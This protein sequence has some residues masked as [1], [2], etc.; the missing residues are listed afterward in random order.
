GQITLEA[1]DFE[2]IQ[3]CGTV[4]HYRANEVVFSEGEPA[5]SV[6]FIESGKVSIFL[7]EFTNRVEIGQREAGSFF[8]EMA[9]LNKGKRTASVTAI[10]DTTLILLDK[11][12]FMRLMDTDCEVN[13]KVNRILALRTEELAL[14]ENLLATTGIKGS[15]L[16]VSIKGDPSMRESAFDRERRESPMDRVLS[17]LVPTLQVLLLERCVSEIS[18]HFNSG[19]IRLTSIFDPFN[20]EIHPANKLIDT[21]Y[22]DRHFPVLAYAEKIRLIR[23]LYDTLASEFG[24]L[25]L[26]GHYK[27]SYVHR[28]HHWQPLAE[29][30]IVRVINKLVTL[31]TIP[32]FYLRNMGISI[33][34]DAIRMQFNC[35]GTH[36][37]STGE[38]DRFLADNLGVEDV[39]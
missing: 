6:Y 34:R 9:V 38:Y 10:T 28:Y 15:H 39:T 32:N 5:E 27:D 14:K 25:P 29:E 37:V 22:L 17:E 4:R 36:I 11:E 20:Y 35:D 2:I 18:L 21:N 13:N 24:N 31:R 16:Q 12:Q 7:H 3:S 8:G 26:P 23:L 33:T 30:E 19:E 1:R